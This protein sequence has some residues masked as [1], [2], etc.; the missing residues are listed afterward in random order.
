MYVIGNVD[1]GVR[2]LPVRWMAPEALRDRAFTSKSDVWSYAIV[3]WE[4]GT[5]GAFPYYDIEDDQLLRHVLRDEGRLE[6]PDNVS[7]GLYDLMRS[8][9][10]SRAENR[11]NF[12]QIV[13]RLQA[14]DEPPK[15]FSATSNPCYSLLPTTPIE[16]CEH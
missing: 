9:W 3:L 7:P 6:R 16:N 14:L 13:R 1:G 15:F 10:S 2:R 4:I 8:C 11:P 5:L 12:G